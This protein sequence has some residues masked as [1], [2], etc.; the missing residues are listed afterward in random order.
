M[1]T[2]ESRQGHNTESALCFLRKLL[3]QLFVF[4]GSLCFLLFEVK[5]IVMYF[6]PIYIAHSENGCKIRWVSPAEFRF[7]KS[8]NMYLKAQALE[9][10]CSRPSWQDNVDQRQRPYPNS[11][12]S[13]A[14]FLIAASLTGVNIFDTSGIVTTCGIGSGDIV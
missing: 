12:L 8:E 1:D 5:Y 2:I 13:S 9:S 14:P 10:L 6:K 7:K 3:I 4:R 11:T